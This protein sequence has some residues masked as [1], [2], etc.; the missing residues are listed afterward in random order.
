MESSK[1]DWTARLNCVMDYVE[2]H[3]HD[4]IEEKEISKITAC[5]YSV[6]Q[7]YFSQITGISF[8]EYVRRRRLT[9]A[10]YDLLNTDKKMMDIALDYGYQSD[11]AF[12]VAFK[13]LY[14]ITPAE[15][16]KT[17]PV[18][19]FYCRIEFE[20]KIKGVDQM[21]YEVVEKEAFQVTGIR[22]TTPY[23]GG[24][25]AIVK[26]DGSNDKMNAL[27][28]KFFDLGL[29]F[30]FDEAGNNDYMC[31]VECPKGIDFENSDFESYSYPATSWLRFEARGKISDNVLGSVWQKI[32]TE[33]LPSSK[34]HKGP[35]P[36]IEKYVLWN[37]AEDTCIVEIWIPQ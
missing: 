9:M 22:R 30:G 25:W 10:A 23:G 14:G 4:T 34:F 11:D 2:K 37:E 28:G 27:A 13:N 35:L 20:I 19:V 32:N 5:Q 16:R 31:A 24:T 33:F 26:S 8:S 1:M 29:C 12:R 15:V 6:F 17:S 3:L 18:L 21:K 36:T 7:S